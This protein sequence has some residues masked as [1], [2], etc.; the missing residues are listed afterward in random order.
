MPKITYI[1]YNGVEHPIDVESGLSL[2]RGAV[3]NGIPG[4]MA[5]CGGTCSC[6]TCKVFVDPQW[7]ELTGAASDM[8]EAI[9]DASDENLPGRRLSCQIN[10]TDELHGLIVRMPLKQF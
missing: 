3:E 7:R 9:L 6:G 4:I 5:D 1:E 8:E 2:M 10:V